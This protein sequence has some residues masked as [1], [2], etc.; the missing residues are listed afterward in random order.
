MWNLTSVRLIGKHA[1]KACCQLSNKNPVIIC[2][3]LHNDQYSDEQRR[4]IDQ[5]RRSQGYNEAFTSLKPNDKMTSFEK[6]MYNIKPLHFIKDTPWTVENI[7]HMMAEAKR[8]VEIQ[9]QGYDELRFE[10]LGYEVGAAH[11]VVYRKGAVKFY[12]QDEWIRWSTEAK[13]SEVAGLPYVN[14]KSYHIAAIDL[15]NVK[16]YYEGLKNFDNL[17]RLK[18]LSLEN[19]PLLDDWYLDYISNFTSL[20]Y[21]SIRNCP[22]VSH[23]GLGILYKLANLKTLLVGNDKNKASKEMQLAVLNLLEYNP[24]LHIDIDPANSKESLASNDN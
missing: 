13:Y 18:Y 16:L 11:F 4:I 12:N 17:K 14:D 24:D 3:S 9:S 5:F 22:G 6:V 2:Q 15:D 7:V 20:E 21:L 19:N 23:R 8:K 10:T 1:T